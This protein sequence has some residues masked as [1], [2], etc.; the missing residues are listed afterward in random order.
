MDRRL[1][2][3]IVMFIFYG[4]FHEKVLGLE[5]W[6]SRRAHGWEFFF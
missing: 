2:P 3:V 5:V 4:A 1:G 6:R